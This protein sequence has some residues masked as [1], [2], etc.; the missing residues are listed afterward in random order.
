S[1]E[2]LYKAGVVMD[3]DAEPKL[4]GY[5]P[6]YLSEDDAGRI[7]VNCKPRTDPQQPWQKAIAKD[8]QYIELCAAVDVRQ[9]YLPG[10]VRLEWQWFDPD[11]DDHPETHGHKACLA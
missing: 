3:G 9:G 7:F 5:Q 4:S 1:V 10:D 2:G 8:T 6:G 11:A